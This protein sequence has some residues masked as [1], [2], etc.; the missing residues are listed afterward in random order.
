[1]IDNDDD[2]GLVYLDFE[3]EVEELPPTPDQPCREPYHHKFEKK[4][5][6]Q[7]YYYECT[8]CGY[9]PDLDFDKP[10]FKKCHKDYVAWKKT[11]R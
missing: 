10:K 5:L 4:L 6:A 1:M 7:H 9:S 2:F 11:V 3:D 8:L